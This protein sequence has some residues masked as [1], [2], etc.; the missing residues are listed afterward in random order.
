MELETRI[1]YL[2]YILVG[3]IFIIV[4]LALNETESLSTVN[5]YN[6]DQW[7]DFLKPWIGTE[8]NEGLPLPWD[9]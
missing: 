9:Q 7:V 8:E 1:T 2:S 6:F 4:G 5:N 3:I